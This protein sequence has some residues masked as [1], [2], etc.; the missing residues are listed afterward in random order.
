MGLPIQWGTRVSWPC[1]HRGTGDCGSPRRN[2]N[3]PGC[4]LAPQGRG[5]GCQEPWQ[6]SRLSNA[7]ATTE[8]GRW[9]WGPASR[10]APCR[11]GMCAGRE[12]PRTRGSL[13]G[14][15]GG[16]VWARGSGLGSQVGWVRTA[17][18]QVAQDLLLKF[19]GFFWTFY[20]EAVS[21]FPKG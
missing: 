9:S 5:E 3:P 14:G 4:W 6:W 2:L 13:C 20:L 1:H 15:G 11:D 18:S 8:G 7:W 21:K 12:R 10:P 16:I 17:P 19:R